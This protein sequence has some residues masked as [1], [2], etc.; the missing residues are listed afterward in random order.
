MSSEAFVAAY[1]SK[2]N[3]VAAGQINLDLPEKDRIL[4]ILAIR[5]GDAMRVNSGG[6]GQLSQPGFC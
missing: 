3:F 1:R 4:D 6:P 2:K 5:P